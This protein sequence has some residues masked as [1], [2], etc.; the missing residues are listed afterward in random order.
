MIGITD[1]MPMPQLRIINHSLARIALYLASLRH[2]ASR[3]GFML[4]RRWVV[5]ALAIMGA[6][7]FAANKSSAAALSASDR[8]IYQSAFIAV[9]DDK[10]PVAEALATRRIGRSRDPT[11]TARRPTIIR[12]KAHGSMMARANTTQRTRQHEPFR[13]AK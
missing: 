12:S 4:S 8:A 7:G 5:F 3:K 2:F 1:E 13:L 6:V 10:W 11:P 9:E